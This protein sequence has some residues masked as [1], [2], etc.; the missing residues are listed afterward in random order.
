MCHSVAESVEDATLGPVAFCAQAS[1]AEMAFDGTVTVL[2]LSLQTRGISSCALTALVSF[3][4]SPSS[5]PAQRTP[6]ARF[7]RRSPHP[8][9]A[10]PLQRVLH[11]HPL[12][13]YFG[14]RSKPHA[15]MGF[16]QHH[17]FYESSFRKPCKGEVDK[18]AAIDKMKQELEAP[19][20]SH[21]ATQT[22]SRQR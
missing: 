6:P 3:S 17:M 13:D 22:G 21:D 15:P 18:N 14:R 20:Q 11:Q 16:S 12:L 19:R 10:G 4:S 9:H 1:A 8:D 2:L 7:G 5:P